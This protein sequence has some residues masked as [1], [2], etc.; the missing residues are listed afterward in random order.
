MKT[1]LVPEMMM[2]QIW[3]LLEKLR[4]HDS[5]MHHLLY[6]FHQMRQYRLKEYGHLTES[7]KMASLRNLQKAMYLLKRIILTRLRFVPNRFLNV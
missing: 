1:F 5:R 6:R 3:N 7:C 2:M 4:F